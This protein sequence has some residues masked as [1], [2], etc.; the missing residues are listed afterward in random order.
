M[1]KF[2]RIAI[3]IL[4]GYA[5]APASH[6]ATMLSTGSYAAGEFVQVFGSTNTGPGKYRFDIQFSTTP[7]YVYGYAEKTTVTNF[8]CSDPSISP[9]IFYCGGDDVPT[10]YD[11]MPS[12]PTLYSATVTVAPPSSTP[13]LSDPI[14][15]YDDFETCCTYQFDF[16]SSS[17]GSYIFSVSA[18]PEPASWALMIMGFAAAGVAMRR[19]ARL[20]FQPCGVS[21][22]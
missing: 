19:K 13:F 16:D 21:A 9:G 3:S 14:V 20:A 8:Y 1:K 18:V 22:A 17:A 12:G 4:A 10:L 6:A 11:F 5:F 2:A 15:R 7:N